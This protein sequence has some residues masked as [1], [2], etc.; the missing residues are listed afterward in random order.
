MNPTLKMALVETKLLWREPGTWLT[1]VL[2]PV[3]I[4]V[5]LGAIPALRTPAETFGGQRFIDLFVPSLVVMSLATLGANTMPLRLASYREKGVLRRLA[6]TPVNPAALLAVQLAINSAVA[7]VAVGL[8]IAAGRL[9]FQIPLP[10]HLPGFLAALLLGMSSLFAL[11]LLIAAVAPT[12]RAATAAVAPV[13]IVVMVLGGVYVPRIFLPAFL[14]R[15]GAFTPP[16]VQAMLDAWMGI[17]PDPLPLV[18]MAVTTVVAGLAAA[19]LFRW[20]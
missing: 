3:F 15:F 5:V 16:G 7:L 4:L 10:Q 14:V 13:F 19:R 9:A 6:T 12:A 8:L 20:Q 1:G 2:L 18:V 11:G 17:A